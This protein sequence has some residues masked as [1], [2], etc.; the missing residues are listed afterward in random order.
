M[1]DHAFG[2]SCRSHVAR[3]WNR[4]EHW[5]TAEVDYL[6]TWFGRRSDESIARSLGRSVLA[7][8]LRAKRAGIRKRDAGL[9]S[10]DV[11][12]IF[13][14]DDGVVSKSWIRS[15]LLDARRGAFRQGPHA[16]W[17]IEDAAIE[18][19]IR[20]HGQYVDPDR[21][22]DSHFRDLACRHR[23]YSLPEVEHLTGR[24][25]HSL[26]TSLRKGLYSGVKRGTRWYVPASELP[27]IASRV[28][29]VGRWTTLAR[30]RH[31]RELR[32]AERRNR[33]KGLAA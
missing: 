28:L 24:D 20:N 26:A 15:G 23:F 25:S 1:R 33:R 18:R 29:R 17:L 22:P 21:M 27:R 12:R 16:M 6:E 2:C 31:E 13:G 3:R 10:R 4:S 32:L 5:S 30:V 11:A 8:R 9:S 7:V 14:V 19:F